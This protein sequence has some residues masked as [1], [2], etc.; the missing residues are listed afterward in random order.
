MKTTFPISLLILFASCS[1][2]TSSPLDQSV[3]LTNNSTVSL[4]YSVIGLKTSYRVDPA[5]TISLETNRL[6]ELKPSKD[7]SLQ[8]IA[9]YEQEE[10]L[11]VFVYKIRSVEGNT[12]LQL[13]E[14]RQVTYEELKA[15]KPIPLQ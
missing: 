4:F 1:T 10:G 12:V 15:G 14:T 11:T 6:P 13:T 8:P 2:P 3:V 7:V 5:P 9:T